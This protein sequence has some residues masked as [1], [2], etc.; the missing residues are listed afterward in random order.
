MH[1]ISLIQAATS[2]A[3]HTETS[4][5]LLSVSMTDGEDIA[6]LPEAIPLVMCSDLFDGPQILGFDSVNQAVTRFNEIVSGLVV[7]HFHCPYTITLV[8]GRGD[9]VVASNIC[10]IGPDDGHPVASATFGRIGFRTEPATFFQ[11]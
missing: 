1:T 8:D 9:T 11:S 4:V 6:R 5:I 10:G 7:G 2:H 3:A